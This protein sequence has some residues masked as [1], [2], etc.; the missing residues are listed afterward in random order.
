MKDHNSKSIKEMIKE[1]F[2]EHTINSTAHEAWVIN[3]KIECLKIDH[4]IAKCRLKNLK[5]A[6]LIL[7]ENVDKDE[8]VLKELESIISTLKTDIKRMK[9]RL[10]KLKKL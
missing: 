7:C 6:W 8:A 9:E 4:S 2:N 1:I 10:K 3:N 5:K